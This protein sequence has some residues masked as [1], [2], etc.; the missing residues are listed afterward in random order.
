MN[1]DTISNLANKIGDKAPEVVSSLAS[2]ILQKVGIETDNLQLK[3]IVFLI[4]A[5]IGFVATKI[6][7]KLIK[8]LIIILTIVLAGT[9]GF[10]L[11]G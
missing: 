8:W 9:L 4:I 11:F 2:K 7:N 3:I 6:S 5:I 10:S 1:N